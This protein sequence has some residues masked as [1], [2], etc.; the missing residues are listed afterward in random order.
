MAWSEEELMNDTGDKILEQYQIPVEGFYNYYAVP[1]DL[2]KYVKFPTDKI[3]AGYKSNTLGF[4]SS[5][6]DTDR[7]KV[8]N[9]RIH[10]FMETCYLGSARDTDTHRLKF[11]V[12]DR[13][14]LEL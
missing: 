7:G 10:R 13:T 5:F 11:I 14:E 12:G 1:W 4:V 9:K 3:V 6:G 2:G 8:E